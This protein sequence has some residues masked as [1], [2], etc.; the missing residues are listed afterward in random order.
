MSFLTEINELLNIDSI[1]SDMCVTFMAGKGAVIEGYKKILNITDDCLVVVGKNKR[2][3]CV[4][5]KNLVLHSLASSEIVVHGKIEWVG[6]QN[7]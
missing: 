7:D 1:S 5:G 2:K 4:K 3:I 6:E